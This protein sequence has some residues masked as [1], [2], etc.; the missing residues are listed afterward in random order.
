M[1]TN[2]ISESVRNFI[3]E[4]VD[5]IESFEILL[6]LHANPTRSWTIPALA[7]ELRSNPNSAESR[8]QV[9]RSLNIITDDQ[10]AA[11]EYQYSLNNRYHTIIDDLAHHYRIQRHK[12]YELIFSP[13]K[14]ARDFADAF[15][16]PESKDGKQDG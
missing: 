8:I 15:R 9:W 10:R 11:G 2:A 3:F 13:L 1:A 7:A 16:K 6:F 14:K 5:S 12:I 4:H